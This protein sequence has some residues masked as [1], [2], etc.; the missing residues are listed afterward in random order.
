MSI[1][2]TQNPISAQGITGRGYYGLGDCVFRVGTSELNEPNFKYL[3]QIFDVAT[4]VAK[5]VIAPNPQGILMFNLYEIARA[6]VKTDSKIFSED[7]S[8][9]FL[10]AVN[11]AAAEPFSRNATGLKR[12]EVRFGE[13]YDVAGVPTEFPGAGVLGTDSFQVFFLPWLLQDS[14][15]AY[16]QGLTRWNLGTVSSI[17]LPL[18]NITSGVYQHPESIAW[19]IH[20]SKQIPVRQSDYGVIA[21]PHDVL[22][23]D[24]YNNTGEVYYELFNGVTSV[25]SATITVNTANGAG[26]GASTTEQ[27]K[28]IYHGAYPANLTNTGSTISALIWPGGPF[29]GDDWTHYVLKY[30]AV[31]SPSFC[32]PLYFV[33][34]PDVSCRYDNV[35]IAWVNEK[36]GWDY[37]N[38]DKKNEHEWTSD[39]K[40]FNKINGTYS[41]LTF[42]KNNFERGTTIFSKSVDKMYTITSDWLTEEGFTFIKGMFLSKEV[43]IIDT[44]NLTHIPVT[45]EDKTFLQRSIRFAQPFNVTMKLKLSQ[46]YNA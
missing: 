33:K 36:G 8:L 31:G 38:F 13:K 37:W 30:S 5:F 11:G 9:H 10:T 14:D 34:V 22:T 40:T 45:I 3:V 35:R 27:D 46:L 7:Y 44:I 41:G 32:L 26:N 6:Y 16:P 2:V 19:G 23:I 21:F 4:Q 28:L 42:V 20:N 17:N 43:H 15:G 24:Q 1:S 12:L 18:T 39:N 29:V 25:G